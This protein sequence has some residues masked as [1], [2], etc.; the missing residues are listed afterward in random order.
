MVVVVWCGVVVR[1]TSRKTKSRTKS[2]YQSRRNK[3]AS[4][5]GSRDARGGAWTWTGDSKVRGPEVQVNSDGETR[6]RMFNGGW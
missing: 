6:S 1:C 2:N 3:K 5:G 4:R